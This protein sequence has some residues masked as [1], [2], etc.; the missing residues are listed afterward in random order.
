MPSSS[1]ADDYLNALKADSQRK[2]AETQ[3]R[4]RGEP[5]PPREE[6][7]L[8]VSEPVSVAAEPPPEVNHDHASGGQLS[9]SPYNQRVFLGHG[10]QS[11]SRLGLCGQRSRAAPAQDDSMLR[12]QQHVEEVESRSTQSGEHRKLILPPDC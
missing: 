6:S 7:P 11:V 9:F 4:L 10:G 2:Q 8:P 3:A 12:S 5:L 1:A